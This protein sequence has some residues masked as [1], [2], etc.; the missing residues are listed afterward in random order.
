M[1]KNLFLKIDHVNLSQLT[2]RLIVGEMR[3]GTGLR[4]RTWG[5]GG[6]SHFT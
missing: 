6:R 3:M 1:F 4:S 2:H 5:K